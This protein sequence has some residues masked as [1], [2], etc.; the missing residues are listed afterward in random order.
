MQ[1]GRSHIVVLKVGILVLVQAIHHFLLLKF[2][3]LV[4]FLIEILAYFAVDLI[5]V[6]LIQSLRGY[7]VASL[8][9]AGGLFSEFYFLAMAFL[10]SCLDS[11]KHVLY[12]LVML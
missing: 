7:L 2:V 5:I 9:L 4:L 12:G 1:E 10:E 8:E 3:L 6:Y 11:A